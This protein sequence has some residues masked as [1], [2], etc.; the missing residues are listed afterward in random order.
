[1]KHETSHYKRTHKQNYHFYRFCCH[2]YQI[3]LNFCCLHNWNQKEKQ[4]KRENPTSEIVLLFSIPAFKSDYQI[5]FMI[6]GEKRG[7]G[8]KREKT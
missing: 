6:Q 2:C 4:A 3:K 1:M 8:K 7:G 5:N